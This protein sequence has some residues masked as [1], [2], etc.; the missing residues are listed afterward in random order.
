M[1]G[2]ASGRR[3]R[4]VASGLVAFLATLILL[5][6]TAHAQTTPNPDDQALLERFA[7]VMSVRHQQKECGAGERF[8]PVPVDVVLGRDDVVLRDADNNIVKRAPTAKDLA[9][10]GEDYWLDFPYD[11]LN[12]GCDYEKWFKTMDTTP[13]IYGRVSKADG[14]LVLQYYFYW[15]FNQWN[16][17]HESDWEGIQLQFDT[18]NVD[19]AM[20]SMPSRFAYAQHEGAEYGDAGNDKIQLVDDTHPVVYSSEGSHASYF[21]STRW[22]GKSGSTGFGCDNTTAKVDRIE[23]AVIALPREA[24]TSGKFAWLSYQGHWGEQER[25][26]DDGPTGPASKVRWDDPQG[27]IDDSG[28]ESSVT[29]P[30]AQS[31]AMESF[32]NLSASG[33]AL[34][35][36]VLSDPLKV[37]ALVAVVV[38]GIVMIVRL[39]SRGLMTRAARTWWRH[40]RALLLLGVVVVIGGLLAWLIQFAILEL[41]VLGD[42]IDVVGTSSAWVIPLVAL[43]SAAVLVPVAAWIVGAAMVVE[44][45]EDNAK[46]ALGSAS[47]ARA[48]VLW[49][50]MIVIGILGLSVFVFPF[51]A[52]LA[53]FWLVAPAIG[54]RE[55][56]RASVAL[57]RSF[58][59]LKGYR[60]RAIGLVITLCLLVAF[61]GVVGA[62]VLVIPSVGFTGAVLA[63]AVANAFIIPYAAL[64][65][66]HFYEEVTAD[67]GSPEARPASTP[68]L[69]AAEGPPTS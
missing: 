66:V 24:P 15:V 60:W 19:K 17:L 67:P 42:Y 59:L 48:T 68:T 54:S 44:G 40:R 7:P 1:M 47:G 6:A 34:F 9:G 20:K 62:L 18:G 31:V 2:G 45:G 27:W 35:N 57:R 51:F 5:P 46:H 43:A 55:Q 14:K 50:A 41:T 69:E 8:R 39:S 49:S 52:I 37:I 58:R 36:K 28:R 16:D 61:G 22:F 23:P 11:A 12:P 33:S 63:V 25:F 65:A 30:F 4:F 64:I 10:R 32:C 3:G 21:S 26:F 53:S 56:L 13:S 29:L 38:L